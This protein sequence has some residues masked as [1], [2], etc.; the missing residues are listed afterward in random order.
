[1]TRLHELWR[2]ARRQDATADDDLLRRF[3]RTGDEAAF[4]ELVARYGPVVYGACRRLLAGPADIED[5][6]QATFLV[7]V[8]RAGSLSGAGLGPWLY[9]VAVWTAR[10]LRRRNARRAV[11]ALNHQFPAPPAP[12]VDLR[13]DL[14]AALMALPARYRTPVVLC[15]LRGWSRRD[16]ALRLGCPEGT[17]S[18]RLSRALVKLRKRLAGADPVAVLA[19]VGAT[20]PASTADAAVR[21]AVL[22]HSSFRSAAA[23]SPAVAD[24]TRGVLRMFW[25]KK[26]VATGLAFIAVAAAGLGIGLTGAVGPQASAQAPAA[27]PAADDLKAKRDAL[28]YELQLSKID[29]QAAQARLQQLEARKKELDDLIRR[30]A[31]AAKQELSPSYLEVIVADAG[32]NRLTITVTEYEARSELVGATTPVRRPTPVGKTTCTELGFL[33]THLARVRKDPAAPM[34]L[35]VRVNPADL[36]DKDGGVAAIVAVCKE[37]NFPTFEIGSTTLPGSPKPTLKGFREPDRQSYRVEPPDILKIEAYIRRIPA[38]AATD[39]N[40]VLLELPVAPLRSGEH[41]V[42]PDGTV[43]LGK[44]GA[45]SVSGLTIEQAT[46]AIRKH[47]SE[48]KDVFR[49]EPGTSE[50]LVVVIDVSAS[51][52]KKYY[53]I[54]DTLSGSEQVYAFPYGGNETVVDILKGIDWLSEEASKRN[55]WVAR[56]GADPGLA[57]QI[58]PVDWNGITKQGVT[59]TNYQL[60]PGDRVYVKSKAA[61]ARP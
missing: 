56:P 48:Q 26:A 33:R 54:A 47:L 41:I 24:L 59:T 50:S 28:E 49:R 27:K 4:A 20:V 23:L 30:Q 15:Y 18:A 34:R 46:A 6:F 45:V 14:D 21:S 17:L 19:A 11:V 40:G 5:A 8:T 12:P 22:F 3:D 2:R 9:R 44:Y 43:S 58:L 37:A 39:A 10:N 55:I 35:V 31:E 60:L 36:S 61:A 51:N 57:E 38:G 52:S 13:L 42:R 29:I 32:N 7:L 25:V 1:M 16:A 53:V